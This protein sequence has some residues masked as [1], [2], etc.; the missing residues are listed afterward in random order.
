VVVD[1]GTD[2]AATFRSVLA[3][4]EF[5]TLWL[6]HAQSRVGDQLGRVAL[7]VLVYGRTGSALLTAATYALTLLPP[8]IGAP[9]LS[10]LA[11]RYSRRS[12][13]VLTDVVRATVFLAMSV[14]GLPLPVL[15][16]L[17]VLALT[18]QPLY[19]AARNAILPAVLTGNRYVTGFS[20]IGM[21]DSVSQ[22]VGFGCGGVL[23]GL[24]GPYPSLAVDAVTFVLSAVLV[25]TGLGSHRPTGTRDRADAR[26]AAGGRAASG[27]R[28]ARLWSLALL[29]WSYGWYVAPEGVAAPC[30]RQFG[31]G[32]SGVGLLMAA[33]PVGAGIGAFVLA[34][35]VRPSAR[36]RLIGPLAVA[37]GVP[38]ALSGLRPSLP[39]AL[40]LWTV[41]G[42]AAMYTMLAHTT[43]V[44]LVPDERRGRTVG[45]LGAGLQ[46]A[47]GLGIIA[48]GAV[49]EVVAPSSAVAA[50][51]VIG[52]GGTA[53]AAIAW[54]RARRAVSSATT[55]RS[56]RPGER[57][58][59]T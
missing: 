19:G 5:R 59:P 1:V 35:W 21:T 6:A 36:P 11:D 42:A 12:V 43:F 53:V 47:Q 7:A 20:I 45:L 3:L 30:A 27:W 14:P 37:A 52:T 24:I 55:D 46:A 25:R 39:V 8:L 10:G 17:L 40:A 48:V 58:G 2:R 34:R 4:G 38:L 16:V 23:V 41:T 44:E 29:I 49:A 31:A 56:A 15:A 26:H 18:V 33:D 57:P 13:M 50:F 28:D 54:N 22:L 32:A 9:L 51:G